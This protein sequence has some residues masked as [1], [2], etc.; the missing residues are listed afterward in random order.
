[1]R[2]MLSMTQTVRTRTAA[3]CALLVA[4]GSASI[5]RGQ[6]ST[7]R[8]SPTPAPAPPAPAPAPS[9]APVPPK[10]P[11][12]K[13]VPRLIIEPGKPII[14]TTVPQP[15]GTVPVS[16]TR[17][18]VKP[19]PAN[20]V[21]TP[22]NGSFERPIRTGGGLGGVKV[23]FPNV[24]GR[25]G[26]SVPETWGPV[27]VRPPNQPS[28]G[29]RP[30]PCP[31]PRPRYYRNGSTVSVIGPS[32]AIYSTQSQGSSLSVGSGGVS[33]DLDLGNLQVTFGSQP[34]IYRSDSASNWSTI[35]G[36]YPMEGVAWGSSSSWNDGNIVGRCHTPPRHCGW[37][38]GWWTWYDRVRYYGPVYGSGW[39][40][41]D[42]TMFY[43]ASITDP[44]QAADSM[45][46]QDAEVAVDP[47]VELAAARMHNGNYDSAA[48]VLREYTRSN[49]DD[50][51]A[52]RWLAM[53][54]AADRQ[55]KEA[56]YTFLRAYELNDSMAELPLE[57][58]AMG[59]T[60]GDLR[61]MTGRVLTFA[62]NTKSASAYLMAAVLMDT[63]GLDAQSKKLI[64]EARASG[65]DATLA[66]RVQS[67]FAR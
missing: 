28:P 15:L 19:R 61:E 12:T 54:L 63:R 29:P 60:E 40:N 31:E 38:R 23:K 32:G 35:Y 26:S 67:G 8:P 14:Y 3:L 7:N 16:I 36:T 27:I 9:P 44:A 57:Y 24:L 33:G 30:W 46:A 37:D 41:Y 64:A 17:G 59:F 66:D 39:V 2:S 58:E 10:S 5:S 20:P 18:P 56:T 1:M 53:A 62:R 4:C 50:A 52:W 21:H 43:P 49:P 42:P 65:L 34:P 11:Y 13:P 22:V 45:S 47:L 48:K 55:T 6:A 51:G 25:S